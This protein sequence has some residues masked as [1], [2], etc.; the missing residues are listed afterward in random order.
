MPC[1][2]RSRHMNIRYFCTKDLV[3]RKEVEVEY[4]LTERIVADFFTKPLQR[5]LFLKF[6]DIIMEL[7]SVLPILIRDRSSLKER[8]ERNNGEL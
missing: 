2:K 7:K 4:C 6:R 3:D 5:V 1:S 8:V